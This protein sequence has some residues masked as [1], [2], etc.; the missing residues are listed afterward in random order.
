MSSKSLKDLVSFKKK[1]WYICNV[2]C[3][4]MV[5]VCVGYMH[6]V[7]CY[8]K[9]NFSHVIM[10]YESSIY[11]YTCSMKGMISSSLLTGFRPILLTTEY[12]YHG[13]SVH[14][15]SWPLNTFIMVCPSMPPL[16]H[17]IHL[18]WCVRTWLLL[19][20]EYI[21]HGVSAHASSWPLNTFIMVCPSM[22][23]LDHWIHLSW[24]VCPCLLLTT[25][26]IYHGVSAHASSWPLN[27]FI[28]VCL[29]MPPL[30]HW[31]H[32]SIPHILS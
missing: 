23:P 24:C 26:Y 1:I 18:S 32:L 21:Y 2:V 30:D 4:L 5:C 16:D 14:A 9:H 20:T 10:L 19:T 28:M 7:P 25:E 31:I 3:H 6:I 13:V 29:S 12:I 27:T 8:I 22:P 15:S 11:N 17:W